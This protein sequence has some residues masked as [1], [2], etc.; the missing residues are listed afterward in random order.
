[1]AGDTARR[2]A[3]GYGSYRSSTRKEGKK[4]GSGVVGVALLTHT[5]ACPLDRTNRMVGEY[6]SKSRYH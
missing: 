1:M 6:V 5:C 2:L 4:L 3:D